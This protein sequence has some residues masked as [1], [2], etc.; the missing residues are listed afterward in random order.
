MIAIPSEDMMASHDPGSASL[1]FIP[2][3]RLRGMAY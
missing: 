2:A 3:F 1:F